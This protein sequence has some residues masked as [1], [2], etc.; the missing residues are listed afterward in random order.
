MIFGC[1]TRRRMASSFSIRFSWK[2]AVHTPFYPNLPFAHVALASTSIDHFQRQLNPRGFVD[3]LK[4]R[5]ESAIAEYF[6]HGV[7]P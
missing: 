1:F 2:N 7:M 4:Y 6:T 5:R 3:T